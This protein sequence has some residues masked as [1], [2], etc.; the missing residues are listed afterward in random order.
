MKRQR[1]SLLVVLWIAI[2]YVLV[3]V[4]IIFNVEPQTFHSFFDGGLLGNGIAYNR[5]TWR[6]LSSVHGRANK[7]SAWFPIIE[8]VNQFLFLKMLTSS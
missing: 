8:Y 3:L 1:D 6:Y 7:H 5:E 4:L 2:A